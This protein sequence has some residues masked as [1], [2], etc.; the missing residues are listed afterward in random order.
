MRILSVGNFSNYGISN[1]CLHRHWA[2]KKIGDV[3]S[4]DTT[5]KRNYKRQR[6]RHLL[7][8]NGLPIYLK[9]FNFINR[10]IVDKCKEKKY[11]IIWI[12]KGILI[13]KETLLTIKSLNRSSKIVSYS[14]D[15]M[16]LRHNQSENYLTALPYY[17][18]VFTNKSYILKD[19][20]K[21]GAQQ[22]K[23]VNN[24]FEST[25]HYPRKLSEEDRRKFGGDVGFI[26]S[27]EKERCE[28]ILYLVN[29]GIKV[30]VFGGGK[31]NDYKSYHPNLKIKKGL[32]SEEYSKALQAFKISLCFLRKM[33]YD[34]QTTRSVEI[35][36]CG[37]F[38]L[39]ERTEEHIAMFTEDEEAAYFGTNKELLEKCR[40]YLANSYLRNQVAKNGTKRCTIS[41][42]SNEMTIKEMLYSII[43]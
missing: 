8:R 6:I 36:A 7:F 39:A 43:K 38:M 10:K 27:W 33:N 42:Y 14:P 24:S 32:F 17:D 30:T 2:L 31:W 29:N 4:I 16:A 25:F 22:V 35:P 40:F 23:F 28:S 20:Y 12:D 19:L 18:C 11:D 34:L 21:I 37:G 1:T 26:G 9:D 5:A 41:G 13:S 3:D 15:N